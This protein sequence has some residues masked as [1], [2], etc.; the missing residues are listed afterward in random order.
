MHLG[1]LLRKKLHAKIQK[2]TRQAPTSVTKTLG[3]L[4]ALGAY[5]RWLRGVVAMLACIVF[6]LSLIA[7]EGSNKNA[8]DWII[9][10]LSMLTLPLLVKIY[11]VKAQFAQVTNPIYRHGSTLVNSPHFYQMIAEVALWLSQSPPVLYKAVPLVEMVNFFVFLRLYSVIIYLSNA[12]YGHRTFCRAMATICGIPLNA[13]FYIRTSLVYNKA[14]AVPALLTL[15]WLTLALLYQKAEN[16]SFNDSMWFVF[17]TV[18]TIGY[19]DV[20]PVTLIGRC[21]ALMAWIF[22][23]VFV[24]YVVVLTH[25]TLTLKE[26]E[27]SLYLLFKVNDLS[28]TVKSESARTIQSIWRLHKAKKL[29]DLSIV[30]GYYAWNLVQQLNASRESKELIREAATKFREVQ[31]DRAEVLLPSRRRAARGD[32]V[33]THKPNQATDSRKRNSGRS[34][35]DR[36]RVLENTSE[37]LVVQLRQ[38][39]VLLS[40]AA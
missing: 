14:R 32:L 8:L 29:S 22:A 13:S 3:S 24:G 30:Q 10:G 25:N 34:V 39:N 9:F 17:V 28:K 19:G 4:E 35:V 16:A 7:L 27:R 5:Q 33:H 18:G 38:L 31:G 20:R 36:V 1:K 12:R 21:V 40:E 23:L 6:G 37:D 26:H 11:H 2:V 15:C